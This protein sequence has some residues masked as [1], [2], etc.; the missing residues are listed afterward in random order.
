MPLMPKRVKFRK[1]QRGSNKGKATRG[2]YV[3]FGEYGLQA[4]ENGWITGEQIE[5]SRMA[6]GHFLQDEGMLVIRVFPHKS[7]TAKPA[8]TRMGTGKGE[9]V[10]WVAVV[11]PG[12]VLFELGGVREDVAREALARAAHKVPVK[13]RFVLRRVKV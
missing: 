12:T 1:F 2:N 10:H 3:A 4:L 9:P 11:K 8:E 7:V 5:A 13:T 6:L